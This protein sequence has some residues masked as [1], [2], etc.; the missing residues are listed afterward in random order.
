MFPHQWEHLQEISAY[1]LLS[2]EDLNDPAKF[3]CKWTG[4]G[5]SFVER[6]DLILGS[7][8][9]RMSDSFFGHVHAP[10]SVIVTLARVNDIIL[11]W[12]PECRRPNTLSHDASRRCEGPKPG[13]RLE[14]NLSRIELMP[15]VI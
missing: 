6:R 11:F 13:E 9:L 4:C 14:F 8:F 2:E 15:G 7:T 5:K 10:A 12:C 3:R 1:Q